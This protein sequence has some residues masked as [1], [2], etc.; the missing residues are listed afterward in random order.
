MRLPSRSQLCSAAGRLLV[1]LLSATSLFAAGWPQY[2]GPNHDG[3]SHDRIRTEWTGSLTNPVWRILLTNSLSS[4]TV[5]EGRVFTQTR[6]W[7]GGTSMEVCV[8]LDAA[9]GEEVWDQPV[10][11]ANYPNGGVGFDD[12]P[13]TTPVVEGESVY[14]LGSYLKLSRLEAATG[15]V[16]WTKD[17]GALYGSAI[18]PWQN[19]A[20]PL[21]DEG[22]IYLN[23]SAQTDSLMALRTSDGSLLWRFHQEQLTH[24]TPVL[25]TIHGVRQLIFATQ[26]GLVSLIPE[27]GQLLWKHAYSFRYQS[28]LAVSPVVHEDMV[29]I[30]GAHA[31]GMGSMTIQ[32]TFQEGSWSTAQLWATNNPASHWMTP[33]CHE[34]FLYGQFGIQ[35]FDSIRAQLKCV[36]MRTGTVRW[37]TNGFGR[38]GT[39]LVGGHLVVLVETNHLV[40][41]EASP[42]AYRQ[43][44]RFQAFPYWHGSTNKCWNSPAVCEGRLY[45]RSTSYVACF[46]LSMPKLSLAPPRPSQPGRLQLS[47]R[48]ES[49]APVSADRLP[50][51]EL[52]AA[53]D[54]SEPLEQWLLLT[55]LPVL[56]NGELLFQE[57]ETGPSPRYFILRETE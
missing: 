45:A 39:L 57:V 26:S 8:A 29:F 44:G 51:V 35:S 50:G 19:A 52:R 36:D 24:S 11:R 40:L 38:G 5:A 13:R 55:N 14:V 30:S 43:L 27:T 25:A 9:T 49:G 18:I 10:D 56:Q 16:V 12:G 31:Y 33:V 21:L 48:T 41:A 42:E 15:E 53:D 54:P 34:G 47:A 32:A 20:S 1:V 17:L 28:S 22:R 7:V 4:L 23:V 46:D 3:V 6:R 37:S 2:R